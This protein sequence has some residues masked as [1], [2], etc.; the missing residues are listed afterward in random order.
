[1]AAGM[2]DDDEERVECAIHFVMT[3]QILTDAAIT[4]FE[5]RALFQHHRSIERPF[6]ILMTICRYHCNSVVQYVEPY[7][8]WRGTVIR[9][10]LAEARQFAGKEAAKDVFPQYVRS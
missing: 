10:L 8:D 2:A 1:M 5:P 9:A 3:Q 4:L 6:P 7:L